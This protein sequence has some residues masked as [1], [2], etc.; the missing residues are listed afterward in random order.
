MVNGLDGIKQGF[1]QEANDILKCF[2]KIINDRLYELWQTGNEFFSDLTA[3]VREA[4][5]PEDLTPEKMAVTYRNK[6]Q[7]YK[8]A[9]ALNDELTKIEKVL[10]AGNE[11]LQKIMAQSDTTNGKKGKIEQRA[12]KK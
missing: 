8:D 11:D 12:L 1:C 6:S 2:F 3:Q 7:N 9:I 5:A 10:F 4:I